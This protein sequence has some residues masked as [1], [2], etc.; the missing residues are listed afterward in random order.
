MPPNGT[1]KRRL[2]EREKTLKNSKYISSFS[3]DIYIAITR[4]NHDTWLEN[5]TYRHNNNING[6]LYGSPI[7]ITN[8]IPI[9]AEIYVIEMN[10]TTNEIMGIGKIINLF[11]YKTH[12]EHVYKI[13]KD[14]NYCRYVYLGNQR[15]GKESFTKQLY[16]IC[17]FLECVLFYG[18]GPL[19]KP[20]RGT[21]LKRGMGINKLP[22]SLLKEYNG[23]SLNLDRQIK[24]YFN[25]YFEQQ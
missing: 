16:L 5:A 8:T 14:R 23:K 10:N 25:T 19:D 12:R 3:E 21:H 20:K 13:Y 6:C 24:Y 4:F 7:K 17:W 11:N 2:Q 9:G 15:I 18:Y 1:V 22:P